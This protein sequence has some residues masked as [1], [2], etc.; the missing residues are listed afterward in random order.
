MTKALPDKKT[1]TVSAAAREIIPKL[2]E[3]ETNY[4]VSTD[5][6]QLEPAPA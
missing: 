6:E 5:R 4:V 2:V 3:E 1:E